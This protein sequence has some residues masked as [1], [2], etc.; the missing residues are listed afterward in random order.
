ME[1]GRSY[2]AFAKIATR[3]HDSQTFNDL[4]D[5]GNTNRSVWADSAYRSEV[6][7]ERLKAQGYRSRIH[8]KGVR[9]KP[10]TDWEKQGNKTRSKTRC[11][12]VSI[13]V[14]NFP[15]VSVEKFPQGLVG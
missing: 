8:R 11:R 13:S 5:S 7:E 4:L 2:S 14:Q 6:T 10:L 1:L 3:L 12:V 15:S 9:G